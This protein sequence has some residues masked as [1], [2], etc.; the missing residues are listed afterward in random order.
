MVPDPP[1]LPRLTAP[2]PSSLS[3]QGFAASRTSP[4]SSWAKNA[5]ACHPCHPPL[6]A[7]PAASLAPT[8]VF[9]AGRTQPYSTALS[10]PPQTGCQLNHLST[11]GTGVRFP[12]ARGPTPPPCAMHHQSSGCAEKQEARERRRD[13][14]AS[15]RLQRGHAVRAVAPAQSAR[16]APSQPCWS[17]CF[18]FPSGACARWF[19]SACP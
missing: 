11:P 14:I 10:P 4:S 8:L 13:F 5:I 16:R 2:H 18:D 3:A 6:A 12:R 15:P 9:L 17:R 7:L 1:S 19:P